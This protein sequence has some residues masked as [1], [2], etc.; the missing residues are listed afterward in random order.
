MTDKS[1]A[2][3]RTRAGS[4]WGVIYLTFASFNFLNTNLRLKSCKIHQ[5]IQ[6]VKFCKG[7]DI[8]AS[9]L[10]SLASAR[11]RQL[12]TESSLMM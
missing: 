9:T 11:K 6:K 8:I 4:E 1:P 12:K 2:I 7:C 5:L 10:R 3:Y